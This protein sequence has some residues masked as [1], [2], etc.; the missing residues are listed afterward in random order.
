MTHTFE[1]LGHRDDIQVLRGVAVLIVV[2]YHAGFGLPG[3]FIGV[4]LFFVLS[5]YLIATLLTE[6]IERTGRIDVLAFW[7]RRFRRLLPASLVV[8]LAVSVW[9]W[10]YLPAIDREPI[11]DSVRAAGLYGANLHYLWKA[12]NYLEPATDPEPLLHFWSLSVE[13]QFYF[14]VPLLIA[15][16]A[17]A[18]RS[19]TSPKHTLGSA[20][21]RTRWLAVSVFAVV[22]VL[23]AAYM[24]A[25]INDN[26]PL[27]FFSP[28]SRAWQFGAGAVLGISTLRW[29]GLLGRVTTALGVAGVVFACLT[30]SESMVYPGLAAFVPTIAGLLLL[31]GG[32]SVH[33]LAASVLSPLA[34]LG[35]ASYSFYLWHWPL[36]VATTV[37]TDDGP[38][39]RLVAVAASLALALV[40]LRLVEDPARHSKRLRRAA[41]TVSFVVSGILV[42]VAGTSLLA[43]APTR[44]GDLA[45]DPAAVRAELPGLYKGPTTCDQPFTAATPLICSFG[46]LDEDA[47]VILAVGDSHIGQWFSPLL[48][49]A[50]QQG[51][52]LDV[53]TKSSCPIIEGILIVRR[54]SQDRHLACQIYVDEVIQLIADHRADVVVLTHASSYVFIPDGSETDEQ[55][56]SWSARDEW[57]PRLFETL[58]RIGNST[59]AQMVFLGDT[60]DPPTDIPRCISENPDDFVDVCSFDFDP[61]LS[62]A[63]VEIARNAGWLTIETT[64]WICRDGACPAVVG[65]LIAFRDANHISDELARSLEPLLEE[66]LDPFLAA[67]T[68]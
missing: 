28:F 24:F 16:S 42:V 43:N 39:A 59:T 13:E 51:A 26:P 64:P 56:E 15:G 67:A 27:A 21:P 47:P 19:W 14:V 62:S 63:D 8:L 18:L 10:L 44:D 9:T 20:N 52:R 48:A 23:S 61:G 12:R 5:G 58:T 25:V 33:E 4:D 7:G 29:E 57:E 55:L 66:A 50:D 41:P 31:L 22:T 38:V 68:E 36:L 49:V 34:K 32:R 30:F 65:D 54:N 60:P 17:W 45:L 40:T 11:S 6:E 35:T 46:S 1:P 37:H 53:V 2:V 3:G